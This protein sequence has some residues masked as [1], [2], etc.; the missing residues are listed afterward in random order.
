MH[1]GEGNTM[2]IQSTKITFNSLF[3]IQVFGK[4]GP[5][6]STQEGAQVD[7]PDD[8]IEVSDDN[9]YE[10]N[11]KEDLEREIIKNCE[12]EKNDGP[13]IQIC[14]PNTCLIKKNT[15]SFNKNG[16]EVISADPKIIDNQISKNTGNGIF[17]KSVENLYSIPF[18]KGNTIRSNRESGILCSGKRNIAKIRDNQEI[19]FNKLCGIKVDMLASPYIIKNKIT[20]N[21]FQGILIVENSQAHIELNEI[22][23]NIKANIA[24]GGE[25]SA[26]TVIVNN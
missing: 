6:K 20:K 2:K 26:N 4:T 14:C 18:V 16:I 21:I 24:F 8:S 15:I 11:I 10:V 13:G 23:E 19:S 7:D 5:P 3:G 25:N 9:I 12:I 17:I 22:S 1:M